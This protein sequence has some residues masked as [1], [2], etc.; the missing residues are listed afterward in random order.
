MLLRTNQAFHRLLLVHDILERMM[1]SG[2]TDDII[3]QKSQRWVRSG[4]MYIVQKNNAMTLETVRDHVDGPATS[5]WRW[6]SLV[7]VGEELT[8]HTAAD[9]P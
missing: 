3:F 8:Q 9:G 6:L 1:V 4:R 7:V 2:M 5:T